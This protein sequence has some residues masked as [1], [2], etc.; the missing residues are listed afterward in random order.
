MRA[1][2]PRRDQ[3]A[4]HRSGGWGCRQ[5]ASPSYCPFPFPAPAPTPAPFSNP[6]AFLSS[7]FNNAHFLPPS[8]PH[9]AYN[10]LQA[11]WAERLDTALL[12]SRLRHTSSHAVAGSGSG[13]KAVGGAAMLSLEED[14]GREVSAD[15]GVLLPVDRLLLEVRQCGRFGAPAMQCVGMRWAVACHGVVWC[16]AVRAQRCDPACCTAACR[17][18]ICAFVHG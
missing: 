12:S 1:C 5:R 3:R 15:D 16:G 18:L 4:A 6:L 2:A 10:V 11:W 9:P 17:W 7:F 13:A 14:G 8:C